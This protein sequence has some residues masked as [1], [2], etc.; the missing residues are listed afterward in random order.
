MSSYPEWSKNEQVFE[1]FNCKENKT[2]Q[3]RSILIPSQKSNIGSDDSLKMLTE[4]ASNDPSTTETWYYA[5]TCREAEEIMK[6]GF[7][8]IRCMKNRNFSD[9]DGFY[10]T[11]SISSAKELFQHNAFKDFGEFPD[12]EY[13]KR[14]TKAELNH[15][16]FVVLAFTYHKEENNLL[17]KYKK[18]S[19]DLRGQAHEERLKKIVRFFSKD[20]LPT[21]LP[22]IEEHGLNS[23]YDRDIEY[24]IG[25]HVIISS[26]NVYVNW[27]LTQLCVR[28]MGRTSMKKDFESLIQKEVFVLE[29]DD[30]NTCK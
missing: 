27:T 10:F 6:N 4:S 22:T 25:P 14:K 24:I 26:S 15:L 19:I 23:D 20:P 30:N 12:I 16:K 28:C 29:M 2:K 9:S 13:K 21:R 7:S 17:E 5:A 18:H 11:N 1:V 8:F 3:Y